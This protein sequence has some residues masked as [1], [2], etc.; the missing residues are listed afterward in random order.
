MGKMEVRG[1]GREEEETGE[2]TNKM[3]PSK[4][5]RW[6]HRGLIEQGRREQDREAEGMEVASWKDGGMEGIV[7]RD[8]RWRGEAVR[9]E[10]G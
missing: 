1:K 5:R 8:K 9:P 4:Q 7:L 2:E 3:A 6:A 10:M